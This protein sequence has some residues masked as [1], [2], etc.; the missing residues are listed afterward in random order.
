M[1]ARLEKASR[2][3][4]ATAPIHRPRDR[5]LVRTLAAWSAL[6]CRLAPPF[7]ALSVAGHPMRSLRFFFLFAKLFVE[8]LSPSL[9]LN[10]QLSLSFITQLFQSRLIPKSSFYI[11]LR[12]HGL[13][14]LPTLLP[15]F[16]FKS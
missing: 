3:C 2:L 1:A 16:E 10:F 13:L 14:P 9:F 15:F 12:A 5:L 4:G 8:L 6:H 7:F 11:E